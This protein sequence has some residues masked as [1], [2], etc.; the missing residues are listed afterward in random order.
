VAV[1]GLGPARRPLEAATHGHAVIV[2]KGVEV[3]RLSFDDLRRIF[4][5]R[6]TLWKTGVLINV[7]LPAGGTSTRAFM[8][9]HV[10]RMPDDELR[11]FIL[12]RIFQGEIDFAPKVVRSDR[13]AVAFVASGRSLIAIVDA[14]TPGLDSVKVVPVDGLDS[15]EGALA[16]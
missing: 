10:Y 13:D 6:R 8:L 5:F 12:Q 15:A 9:Q 3:D 11:R 16:R 1:L 2:S 4:M 7:L 14:D